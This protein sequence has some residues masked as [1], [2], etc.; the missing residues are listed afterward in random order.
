LKWL[1]IVLIPQEPFP[2]LDRLHFVINYNPEKAVMKKYR[3]LPIFLSI[4]FLLSACGPRNE[5]SSYTYTDVPQDFGFLPF[6]FQYPTSWVLE[7]G[8]GRVAFASEPNILANVPETMEPDQILG[9]LTTNINMP[10]EEMVDYYASTH[11]GVILFKE[12]VMLELNGRSAAYKEGTEVEK[13]GQIFLIA[14]DMGQNQ[15]GLLVA[16]MAAD[17]LDTWRDTLMKIAESL[18]VD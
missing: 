15:R 18:R 16:K 12:T 9:S 3:Y 4:I 2:H 17:E 5:W 8:N 6:S 14:V 10:P 1:F 11:E 13:G 7:Q